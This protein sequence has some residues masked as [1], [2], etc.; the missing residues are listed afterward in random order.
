MDSLEDEPD[1][2]DDEHEGSAGI[3]DSFL[4]ESACCS[5][6]LGVFVDTLAVV[7]AE[8]DAEEGAEEAAEVDAESDVAVDAVELGASM[9]AGKV[10][11]EFLITFLVRSHW[12]KLV[13]HAG[14]HSSSMPK[15]PLALA[16]RLIVLIWIC[17]LFLC[18]T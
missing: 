5:A 4:E 13:S 12:V 7:D 17:K 9:I 11:K 8:V 6:S 18:R 15:I 10:G 14:D 16:F 3:G 1:E 2:D